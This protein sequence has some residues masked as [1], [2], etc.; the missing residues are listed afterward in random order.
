MY[1]V[2]PGSVHE[3]GVPY[4]WMIA[5]GEVPF[6]EFPL[7]L[8]QMGPAK[9][10]AKRKLETPSSGGVPVTNEGPLRYI[11]TAAKN[12]AKE[13]TEAEDGKRN[14]TLF[15]VAVAFARDCA[16]AG[17]DWG[18]YSR[19][20]AEAA[21]AIGLAPSEVQ[22]TLESARVAGSNERHGCGQPLSTSILALRISSITS[23]A[24][25]T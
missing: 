25:P 7:A 11:A 4:E 19:P 6:A 17:A 2:A 18:D 13:I 5:P 10:R 23:R 3:N 24:A 1:V 16:G 8:Q 9:G 20:L 14:N 15:R 12:A 22:A 21:L